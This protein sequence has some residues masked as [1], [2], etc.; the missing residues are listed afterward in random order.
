MENFNSDKF[1]SFLHF[2]NFVLPEEGIMELDE[3]TVNEVIKISLGEHLFTIS[4]K[5]W[6][7]FCKIVEKEELGEL[8]QMLEEVDGP[9][10]YSTKPSV[11][12]FYFKKS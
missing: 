12:D 10:K 3:D 8:L 9:F 2:A 11:D 6:N 1:V 5:F 4:K 7:K